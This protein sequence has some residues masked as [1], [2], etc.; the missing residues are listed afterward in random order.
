LFG[1][2]RCELQR[3]WPAGKITQQIIELLLKALVRAG[4]GIGSLEFLEWRDEC[5][6]DVAAAEGTVAPA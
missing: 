3:R 4:F 2:T 1:K 5:F 6:W